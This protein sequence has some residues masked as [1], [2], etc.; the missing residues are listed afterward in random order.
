MNNNLI[1]MQ[2]MLLRQ[3]KR[4][5]EMDDA[6]GVNRQEE[7]SRANALSQSAVTFLKSVNVGLRI[8]EVSKKFETDKDKLSKELGVSYEK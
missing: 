8:I 2:E 6:N 7:I 3:M 4:L 1:T 5:D